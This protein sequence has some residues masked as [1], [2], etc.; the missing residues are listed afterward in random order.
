MSAHYFSAGMF[1]LLITSGSTLFAT[2]LDF[3]QGAK[4]LTKIMAARAD[5]KIALVTYESHQLQ[6]IISL[7]SMEL[8]CYIVKT[9]L[10]TY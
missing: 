8:A 1:A 10:G 5:H 3:S 6:F 2:H 4:E 7:S 9:T